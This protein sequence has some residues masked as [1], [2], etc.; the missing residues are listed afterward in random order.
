MN[1]C[2]KTEKVKN[3]LNMTHFNSNLLYWVT[4][5]CRKLAKWMNYATTERRNW[6]NYYLYCRYKPT[7]TLQAPCLSTPAESTP[8]KSPVKI[9]SVQSLP[10]E[11]CL[12]FL[13][14]R[15]NYITYFTPRKILHHWQ[16]PV[17]FWVSP[18][19]FW[20]YPCDITDTPWCV[21]TSH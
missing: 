10:G 2:R 11:K 13:P 21:A 14:P 18:D 1:K 12:D 17:N 20:Y 19:E 3:F 7:L 6:R 5:C 8:E 15:Q 9:C 16:S 4:M